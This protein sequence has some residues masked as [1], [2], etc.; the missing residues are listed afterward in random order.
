[1]Q[2]LDRDDL[3][4]SELPIGQQQIILAAVQQLNSQP[5]V[6][7]MPIS[8]TQDATV[9]PLSNTVVG[10]KVGHL[11]TQSNG[12]SSSDVRDKKDLNNCCC[13]WCMQI[14]LERLM[15]DSRVERRVVF[16]MTFM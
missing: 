7:N 11:M 4:R 10:N 14:V 2:L 15:V 5:E 3:K 12:T 8:T 13:V 6:T 16:R 9:N 1:M